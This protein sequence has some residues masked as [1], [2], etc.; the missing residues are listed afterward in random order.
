MAD[1]TPYSR[2][3][4]STS[5]EKTMRKK[6][7]REVLKN[8]GEIVID[9]TVDRMQFIEV[10]PING[11]RLVLWVKCAWKP[12]TLGNCAVQLDFPSKKKS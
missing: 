10:Q 2:S 8:I 11:P 4:E 6:L 3:D 7:A 9:R 5:R 12:G 1:K